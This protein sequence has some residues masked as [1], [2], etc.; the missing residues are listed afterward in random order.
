MGSG[1]DAG[2]IW[3]RPEPAERKPRYTRQQIARVALSIADDDGF[4]AV[5]MKRIA[6]ELGA[7]PMTLYYYV[8]TKTDIIALMQDA[9]LEDLLVPADELPRGWRDALAEITRRTRDVYV[10]H[11][12][13][14]GSL[15][16][17]QFGPNAARHY[18]QS[19]SVLAGTNLSP[20]EKIQV[21]GVLDDYVAG[22]AL[23]TVETYERMRVAASKP[24]LMKESLAYGEALVATGEFPEL[25]AMSRSAAAPLAPDGPATALN[26]QFEI[27]LAALLDGLERRFAIRE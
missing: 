21:I 23:H 7:A 1:S 22:A 13:S 8:R 3:T 25:E 20:L 15:N 2:L 19:L 11:P 18:E 26:R 12:W 6:R 5:T 17:A 27:G 24:D 10:R 4:D 16:E 9:I 14:L